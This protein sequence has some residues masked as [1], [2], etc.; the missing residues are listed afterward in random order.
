VLSP[1]GGSQIPFYYMSKLGGNNYVRG[2]D[3][4]RYYTN[5]MLFFSGEIRRTVW[6]QREDRGLDAVV[7]ADV[8]QGWGDRRSR[9]DPTV[10]ANDQFDSSNWRASFG[11]GVTYRY[12]KSVAFRVDFASSYQKSTVHFNFSRGF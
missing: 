9:T 2:Y 3:N 4:F 7:W 5:N 10:I 6:V 11:G 1:Q 8:G 12:S